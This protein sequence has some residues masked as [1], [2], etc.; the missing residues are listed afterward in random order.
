METQASWMGLVA[1]HCNAINLIGI[2]FGCDIGWFLE[3][4]IG[5]GQVF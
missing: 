2:E 5:L 3:F 4:L 1:H